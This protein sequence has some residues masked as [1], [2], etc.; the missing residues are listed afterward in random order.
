MWPFASYTTPE[1]TPRRGQRR[2][3]GP[4][5]PTAL[6]MFTTLAAAFSTA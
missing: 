1:P 6:P 4:H 5:A 3:C 2:P